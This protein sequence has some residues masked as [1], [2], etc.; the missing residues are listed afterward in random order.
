MITTPADPI[1]AFLTAYFRDHLVRDRNLSP[2]TL[3]SYRDTFKMFLR[4]AS[5]ET[6]RRCTDLTFDD[7]D[8]ACVRRFLGYLED[9]RGNSVRSRNQRLAAIRSFF[10]YV[11]GREPPLMDS[12]RAVTS[13]PFKKGA[14]AEIDY[15]E[16]DEIHAIFQAIN[17]G[18]PTGLRDFALLLFMYNSGAR[19]QEV[20]DLR[21]AWLTLTKPYRVSLLG[22]GRRW[23]VCPLWTATGEALR[24]YIKGRAPRNDDERVFLNRFGR[25][26]SRFGIR[27]VVKNYVGRA[28]PR[29]P[30]LAAKRISPHTVR[31]TTAMHLLQSGVELNVIRGWLGHASLDTTH[32]YAQIDIEM[33]ARALEHCES[34][35]QRSDEPGNL[36]TWKRSPDILDWLESL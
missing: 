13:V 24:D 15:M 18:T 22:K 19:V 7:I 11:A 9:E 14:R 33:K 35:F 17:L 21:V 8:A 25:P 31:H 28:V 23:R 6:G 16:R 10:N 30:R 26:L 27:N 34:T 29:M 12:S 4:F 1:T 20:A 2:N 36:P 32:H 3:V 5:R